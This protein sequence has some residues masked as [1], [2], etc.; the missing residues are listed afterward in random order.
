[1]KKY[2]KF[3][4]SLFLIAF[5]QSVSFSQSIHFVNQSNRNVYINKVTILGEGSFPYTIE[6][7]NNIQSIP[8]QTRDAAVYNVYMENKSGGSGTN[9]GKYYLLQDNDTIILNN[10]KGVLQLSCQNNL[11]RTNELRIA[12]DL[13]AGTPVKPF[14]T[15]NLKNILALEGKNIS[16][17]R[18]DYLIDSMSVPI[19]RY[20]NKYSLEKH[21]D[22]SVSK[23][24][25]YNFMGMRYR[26]KLSFV[27]ST[28]PANKIK[29]DAF[30]RDSVKKWSE[31]FDCLNCSNI[32]LY[33]SA[34]KKVFDLLYQDLSPAEHLKAIAGNTKESTKDF[35]L[36][37]YISDQLDSNAKNISDLMSLY[38]ELCTNPI[39][40]KN[41]ADNYSL[42]SA[43]QSLSKG[44]AMLMSSDKTQ[45]AFD[46]LI[47]KYKG[48]IIYIDFWASWCHPC[49]EEMPF[50]VKLRNRLKTDSKIQMVYISI[51][52]DFGSWYRMDNEKNLGGPNSFILMDAGKDALSKKLNLI[53][54]PRYII[55]GKDGEFI[56]IDAIRP[57]DANIYGLL[58]RL[59]SK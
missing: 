1:M 11:K 57:S 42:K 34:A 14:Y 24:Y 40:R 33:N 58:A 49:L 17:K 55:I 41:V 23:L 51:D 30:Y 4:G 56:N 36:S 59:A 21:V 38:N 7:N 6:P 50:S 46:D 45:I 39:Y 3:W 16:L 43:K 47:R 27:S 54:I 48:Q 15:L 52:K 19:I 28:S 9:E 8:L 29:L 26:F 31:E 32:P 25:L 53:S 35:L 2:F 10:V 22:P 37:A 13:M 44:T 20:I 12:D 5:L 18:R